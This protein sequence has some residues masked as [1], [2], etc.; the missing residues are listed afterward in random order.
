MVEGRIL[1]AV[2]LDDFR[3]DVVV[4]SG[5]SG[6]VFLVAIVTGGVNTG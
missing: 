1:D 4:D 6:G 5:G 2:I 3:G